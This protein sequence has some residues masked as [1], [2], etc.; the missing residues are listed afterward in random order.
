MVGSTSIKKPISESQED[1]KTILIV[2]DEPLIREILQRQF[3]KEGFVVSSCENGQ[4]ALA[5]FKKSPPKVILSDIRMPKGDGV[6]LL[7]EIMKIRADFPFVFMTGFTDVPSHDVYHKGAAA[8]IKKP[9]DLDSIVDQIKYSLIPNKKRWTEKVFGA[10]GDLQLAFDSL[11][12]AIKDQSLSWGRGGFSFSKDVPVD[13]G[14]VV[15]FTLDFNNGPVTKIHGV[16][17]VRWNL[18]GGARGFQKV[19]VEISSL[20]AACLEPVV[21]LADG[22]GHSAYIPARIDSPS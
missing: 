7:E 18:S 10:K 2:D 17:V 13:T 9:F 5:E 20:D 14:E 6:F 15:E 11:D 22:R 12:D 16:G 1:V 21:K 3:K 4:D 19:G 8:L